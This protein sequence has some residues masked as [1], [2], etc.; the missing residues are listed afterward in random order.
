MKAS[1]AL[2]ALSAVHAV[3]VA[4]PAIYALLYEPAM[5]PIT[6][7]VRRWDAESARLPLVYASSDIAAVA[8]PVTLAYFIFDFLLV[9]VWEGTFAVRRCV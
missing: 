1:W 7:A 3:A 2:K 9:P 8:V 5:A 6:A 4:V